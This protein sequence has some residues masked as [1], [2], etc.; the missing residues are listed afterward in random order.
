MSF[1]LPGGGKVGIIAETRRAAQHGERS[2]LPESCVCAPPPAIPPMSTVRNV[3]FIMR[4]QLRRDLEAC[5]GATWN[6]VALVIRD[7]DSR[8]A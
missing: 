3:L 1:A 7:P 4:D 6:R 2:A 5:C 8:A